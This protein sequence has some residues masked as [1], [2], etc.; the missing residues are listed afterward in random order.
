MR[1]SIT[2][3]AVAL[4]LV[5]VIGYSA[6]SL[7]GGASP[8]AFFPDGGMVD[9]PNPEMQAP[10]APSPGV[11]PS[12]LPTPASTAKPRPKPKPQPAPS[13]ATLTYQEALATYGKFRIEFLQCH[14]NPGT[15]NVKVGTKIMLDNKDVVMRTITIG[16]QVAFVGGRSFAIPTLSE[17]GNHAVLC[18]GG[19]AARINVQP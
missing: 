13:A 1:L 18:D 5:A 19:G 6:W 7:Q 16:S 4:F 8:F 2:T 14:G 17:V 10:P 11:S 3:G 15:L 12:P 9:R